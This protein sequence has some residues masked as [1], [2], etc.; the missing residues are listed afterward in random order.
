MAMAKRAQ[1]LVTRPVWLGQ[2]D[3]WLQA[4][5]EAAVCAK[6]C[7]IS[8]PLQRLACI[9]QA[10]EQ[11][12]VPLVESLCND[13]VPGPVWLVATS[14]SACQALA[15]LPRLCRSLLQLGARVRLAAIG[16]ASAQAL[17][18]VLR[19]G[20]ALDEAS[21]DILTAA[22]VG[23]AETLAREMVGRLEGE[24]PAFLLE[25][26][27][28]RPRLAEVLSQAGFRVLRLPIYARSPENFPA[29]PPS[30]GPRWVLLSSSRLA[31]PAVRGL[32]RQQIA[33][34][35]VIWMGHHSAIEEAV[36]ALVPR[37]AWV[38]VDRL[39]PTTILESI[40]NGSSTP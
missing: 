32:E 23:D 11:A 29:V 17:A 5:R 33:A 35:Q 7:V 15:Q 14:P 20:R 30:E 36:R 8:A 27:D 34:D 21:A 39:T 10:E 9:D 22:S 4:L 18:Q 19:P 38:R 13:P 12:L 25:A 40:S 3:A 26:L 28:N 16:G 1:L 6:V 31:E 2:Q 37:A 24:A